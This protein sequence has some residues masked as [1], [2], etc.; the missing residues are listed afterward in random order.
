VYD[1][2]VVL[3]DIQSLFL[4][5]F[6]DALKTSRRIFFFA[7]DAF[8]MIVYCFAFVR[9]IFVRAKI[10]FDVVAISFADIIVFLTAKALLE[11]AFF[12][13]VFAC[14]MRIIV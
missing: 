8:F 12:F 3:N 2:F 9:K 7:V 5:R 13:E 14:S 10:T 6:D 1:R 4:A 11:F